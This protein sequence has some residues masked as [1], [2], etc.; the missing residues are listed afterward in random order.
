[1]LARTKTCSGESWKAKSVR[2]AAYYHSVS[3]QLEE[4]DRLPSN[5]IVHC[6]VT[7]H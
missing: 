2:N 6:F 3:L 7:F 4:L 1:M 5:G